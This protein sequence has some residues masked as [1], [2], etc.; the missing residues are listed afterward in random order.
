MGRIPEHIIE[1]VQ[2]AT[3]IVSVVQAYIPLKRAGVNFKAPCP[4][5]SEKTPSFV[6]S[7]GKQIY[8]C[9]GCG[10]GGNAFHFLMNL[11]KIT[12]VEAVRDLAQKVNIEI[13]EEQERKTDSFQKRYFELCEFAA[14][15]FVRQLKSSSFA[16]KY[17]EQRKVKPEAA[18]S[19]RIG[20]IPKEWSL[21]IEAAKR[22]GY[23]EKELERSG[24]AVMGRAGWH[25]RFVN[26]LMFPICDVKG[27]VIA[28]GGRTVEN[29]EPKYLNSPETEWFKKRTT[30]YGLNWTKNEIIQQKK[31][32]VLEGY[33]DLVG[34]L[35]SGIKNCVATLG[36]ALT[37]DH[38]RML[39]RYADEIVISYDGDKAGEAASLRGIDLFVQTGAQVRVLML[40]Q[41]LDPDD[42]VLEHG[43]EA[44]KR[45]VDEAPYFLDY[46]LEKLCEQFDP[47][48]PYG[49]RDIARGM[50]QLIQK[51]E[52]PVLKSAW[53][54]KCADKLRISEKVILSQ[55]FA[56]NKYEDRRGFEEKEPVLMKE[57][58]LL[59]I[60]CEVLRYI[61]EKPLFASKACSEL[62]CS[63]FEDPTL[64]QIFEKIKDLSID[65][66]WDGVPSLMS[67]IQ[68]SQ[69]ISFLSALSARPIET[70][71]LEKMFE[72]SL[73]RLRRRRLKKELNHLNKQLAE[74]ER[75]QQD[76]SS[77]LQQILETRQTLEKIDL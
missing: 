22:K 38:V 47:S 60:E 71:H 43:A 73:L 5:H 41:G 72:R 52:D 28:F 77:V 50:L 32:L 69:L 76:V 29:I 75:S 10:A 49:Q 16:Q 66:A 35:Q 44:F 7:P 27:R 2:H 14:D 63:D 39:T 31:V 67:Q 19:F 17:L 57:P 56:E 3:D 30:L 4:F 12:F 9:F 61:F 25:D 21:L 51:I 54:K 20:F 18:E 58:D 48:T 15:F 40:P 13:P 6:V 46:K 37:T 65:G 24:L 45:L 8:H 62:E 70:D 55:S 33:M 74:L 11:E 64:R 34:L 68:D 36:T 23:T 42:Y 59:S 1:Q 53:I 26:R